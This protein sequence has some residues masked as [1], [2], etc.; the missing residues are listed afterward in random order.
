MKNKLTKPNACHDAMAGNGEP[1]GPLIKKT[2]R[3]RYSSIA[4]MYDLMGYKG[5]SS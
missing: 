3:V 5:H 4:L 2:F 1:E